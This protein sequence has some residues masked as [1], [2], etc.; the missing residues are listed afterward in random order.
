MSDFFNQKNASNRPERVSDLE[1][2]PLPVRQDNENA[3]PWFVEQ[4]PTS[5]R[6]IN[7]SAKKIS[8][9]FISVFSTILGLTIALCIIAGVLIFVVGIYE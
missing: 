6:T 5:K 2:R 3:Q 4:D 8:K 1:A 9:R 7:A